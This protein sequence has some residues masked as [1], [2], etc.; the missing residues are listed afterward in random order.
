MGSLTVPVVE[1]EVD[2]APRSLRSDGFTLRIAQSGRPGLASATAERL[3]DVIVIN[4][5]G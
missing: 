5:T 2:S 3:P 4:L 1:D